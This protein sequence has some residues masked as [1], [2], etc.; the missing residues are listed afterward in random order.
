MF[1]DHPERMFDD[2]STISH[3]LSYTIIAHSSQIWNILSS[4]QL[5]YSSCNQCC[6]SRGMSE[7]EADLIGAASP[8][9]E[10]GTAPTR[11]GGCGL[12]LG[13]VHRFCEARTASERQVWRA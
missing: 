7:P 1:T 9:L 12:D 4:S 8:A 3:K 2:E 6:T 13:S 5:R 10:D 11:R